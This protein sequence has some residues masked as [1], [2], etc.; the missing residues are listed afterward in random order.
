MDEKNGKMCKAGHDSLNDLPDELLLRIFKTLSPIELLE[1]QLVNKRF[2]DLVTPLLWHSIYVYD[3]SKEVRAGRCWFDYW[4]MSMGTF[5]HLS[6]LGRLKTQFM[7]KLVFWSDERMSLVWLQRL[8]ERLSEC[9]IMFSKMSQLTVFQ[10][11][12]KTKNFRIT[13]VRWNG[14]ENMC[15]PSDGIIGT[16]SKDIDRIRSI[17]IGHITQEFVA[18]L[19]HMTSLKSL[20]IDHP[21]VFEVQK[22]IRVS[23]LVLGHSSM[24]TNSHNLQ[25]FDL[26]TLESLSVG[27]IESSKWEM[28]SQ[29]LFCIK[30]IE[31][32]NSIKYLPYYS[33][34]E[35]HYL[36]GVPEEDFRF[37]SR[38]AI[39]FM[40][41]N[42]DKPEKKNETYS[43]YQEPKR[44][45]MD[46]WDINRLNHIKTLRKIKVGDLKYRID[47]L[48]GT[49]KYIEIYDD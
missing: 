18:N 10:W 32:Q 7:K 44:Q 35:V 2:N 23:H 39:I 33:L 42:P 13:T 14:Y 49:T 19:P 27:E 40:S 20:H 21:S 9:Q 6:R 1:L 12:L 45:K 22:K 15:I 16:F 46:V 11:F 28:L 31:L 36:K 34:R 38:H 25:N 4:W 37:L 43:Y 5:L 48:N 26:V 8:K 24:S 29:E 41:A 3:S 17:R 47:R 30:E